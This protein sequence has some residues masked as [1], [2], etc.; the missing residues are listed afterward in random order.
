MSILEI[1]QGIARLSRKDR[2][3]VELF[4][5]RLKHAS[6]EWKRDAARKVRDFKA[7][8]A[9]PLEKVERML[10]ARG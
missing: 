2:R 6:P 4:L 7:G 5:L 10:R 1:K 8:K 9:I 3:E